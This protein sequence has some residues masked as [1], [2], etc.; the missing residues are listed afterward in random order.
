MVIF[1]YYTSPGFILLFAATLVPCPA[2]QEG[3]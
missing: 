3:L 1:P 2:N